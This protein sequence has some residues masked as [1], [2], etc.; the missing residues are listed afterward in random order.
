MKILNYLPNY[1]KSFLT[2][3]IDISY[4]LNFDFTT[5]CT[6]EYDNNYILKEYIKFLIELHKNTNKD[7]FFLEL[8]IKDKTFIIKQEHNK[9][10]NSK[11]IC[12]SSDYL[13]N[14]FIKNIRKYDFNNF[15]GINDFKGIKFDNT[16]TLLKN[17]NGFLSV[18]DGKKKQIFDFNFHKDIYKE[19]YLFTNNVF[20]IRKVFAKK[21]IKEELNKHLI[22]LK[23]LVNNF[24]DFKNKQEKSFSEPSRHYS[25]IKNDD[26]KVFS[27]K[28]EDK[29]KL[30][31]KKNGKGYEDIKNEIQIENTD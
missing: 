24:L 4:L 19:Q 2:G 13:Q 8:S 3:R 14:S 23:E 30:I 22:Q 10:K 16:Y 28:I 26:N 15:L 25:V 27:Y 7:L 21:L 31:K 29:T 6:R 1:F 12:Y 18:F 20:K 9:D 17:N 11:L 5:A